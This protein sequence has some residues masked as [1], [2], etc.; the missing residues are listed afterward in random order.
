[1]KRLYTFFALL[2]ALS[3]TNAQQYAF[4]SVG[5]QSI[6]IGTIT[7]KNDLWLI[8]VERNG[9][10]EYYRPVNLPVAYAIPGQEVVFE[11]ARGR[12]ELNG[13]LATVPVKLNMIRVLYRTK[14][15]DAPGETI[16][17]EQNDEQKQV[18]T[19][20]IGFI[21]Q[22]HGTVMQIADVFIIESTIEGELKRYVPEF[23]PDDFKV[24]GSAITFSGVLLKYDP[25]VRMMGAPIR[26]TELMAEEKMAFDSTMLQETVAE[27]FPFDSAGYIQSARGVI[28]LIADT[29]V[30]VVTEEG[31]TTRYLPAM[32]PKQ[33]QVADKV[34]VFSGEL[35]KIPANVRLMGTPITLDT[36]MEQ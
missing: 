9:A 8:Q 24:D 36:I 20:S 29:Y 13:K 16:T 15:P 4:D 33:F 12:K 2:L 14:Q 27:L 30:I 1:M 22:Q 6:T 28:T 10:Y 31:N 3:A 25:Q 32:L 26:I 23:M 21:K 34:V 5:V 7:Q 11:G 19:D 17:R 18:N 35:G